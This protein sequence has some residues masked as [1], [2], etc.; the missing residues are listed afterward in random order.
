MLLQRD[1]TLLASL[2]AVLVAVPVSE[3]FVTYQSNVTTARRFMVNQVQVPEYPYTVSALQSWKAV[4]RQSEGTE[5]WRFAGA[6]A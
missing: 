1:I 4:C 3:A 5:V 6:L 2:I